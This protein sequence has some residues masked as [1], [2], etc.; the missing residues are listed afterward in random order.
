LL[1]R[2]ERQLSLLV[3]GARDLPERQQTMHAS[4][5]WSEDLLEPG[6]QR[7]FW[8]LAVF[9]GSFTLE[10]AEA[11]CAA[12]EGADP[13][14]LDVL[15]GLEAL[16]DQS[17]VQP[18]TVVDGAGAHAAASEEEQERTREGAEAKAGGR[19]GQARFRL[20]NVVR[21]YALERLEATGEAE[22]LRRAHA[23]YFLALAELEDWQ[24]AFDRAGAQWLA[25]LERE[26][27]NC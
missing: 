4:L 8:R 1:A 20:L 24:Q 11:V 27:G 14:G 22:A 17:L 26:H 7:L 9:V 10:A 5:A 16:V 19:S 25:R 13:L 15:G 2:L 18:W 6:E 3:G 23:A 21:E 12:P